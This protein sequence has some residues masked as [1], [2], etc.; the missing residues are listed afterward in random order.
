MI[1]I[2][3]DFPALKTG[4]KIG[5]ILGVNV[6]STQKN[7]VLVN[8]RDLLARKRKFYI[9][10]PNPEIIL[11]AQEDKNLMSALNRATISIPDGVGLKLANPSLKI[12]KGRDLFMSLISLANKKSWRVFLLGGKG[13]EAQTTAEK[14]KLSYKKIKL[15]YASGPILDNEAKPILESDIVIQNDVVARINNFQPRLLFV[16]FG[17]PKQEKWINEWLP[18]LNIGGAM[19]V[20]GTF[21]YISDT[22]RIPPKWVERCGLEWLWRLITQPW[23]IGRIFKAVI[24]FPLKVFWSKTRFG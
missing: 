4:R 20:G 3:D 17:A 14:L 15:E 21:S 6:N 18:K 2:K 11:K 10:T 23:R 13:E 24:I 22:N 16:A 1:T 8:I 5:N 7:K 9:V 12:I 19:V